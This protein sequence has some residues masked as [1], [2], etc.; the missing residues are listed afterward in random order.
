MSNDIDSSLHSILSGEMEGMDDRRFLILALRLIERDMREIKGKLSSIDVALRDSVA[1]K[2]S[3]KESEMEN[4]GHFR[5][6]ET[7]IGACVTKQEFQPVKT[8]VYGF[9]GLILIAVIGALGS[10]PRVWAAMRVM[11][12]RLNP[13]DRGHIKP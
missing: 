1:S 10:R 11:H 5:S 6:I 9:T 13:A 4:D 12:G 2:D 7:S 8:I 3:L